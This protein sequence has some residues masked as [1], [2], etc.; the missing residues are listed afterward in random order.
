MK[1]SRFVPFL[2]QLF[3]LAAFIFKA[4]DD[5]LKAGLD[6]FFAGG[7]R[8]VIIAIHPARGNNNGIIPVTINGKNFKAGAAIFLTG[9]EGN[10][11]EARD[12]DVASESVI[13]CSLNLEGQPAGSYAV[14]VV[15]PDRKRTR[16]KGF[17]V[18]DA[19]VLLP[20]ITSVDPA[21]GY[22]TGRVAVTITGKNLRPGVKIFLYAREKGMI[23][24]REI[25]VVAGE[26]M[27]ECTFNLRGLPAGSYLV[28]A[29]NPDGKQCG[30][31]SF[32][33]LDKPV[34]VL[35]IKSMDPSLGF[36]NG[37]IWVRLNIANIKAGARLVLTGPGGE[38]IKA[39]NLII[40]ENGE[41]L[42]IFDLKGKPAGAYEV[43][44]TNPDGRQA[45]YGGKFTV[46]PAPVGL[47]ELNAGIKPIFFNFD[48]ADI[49]P[50]QAPVLE[51]NLK[52]LREHVQLRIMLN[53][54]ADNQGSDRYNTKLSRRRTEAVRNFLT[55]RGIDSARISIHVYGEKYSGKTGGEKQNP[56]FDRRVEIVLYEY[57]L[58]P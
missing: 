23:Y 19:P 53:G 1:K 9:P 50:D 16:L 35:T 55:A 27:V 57:D 22:N 56:A 31:E 45:V 37:K 26:D 43:R 11:V 48:S 10:R 58:N 14:T 7:L 3:V 44:I 18:I 49:R 39:E 5:I 12:V 15:N 21:R 33:V 51:A 6:C 2:I 30:F 4:D 34:P 36:N 41:M 24:G 47:A 40:D 29:V 38:T 20:A 42:C 54:Y 8:P 28:A 17:A 52:I 13:R 46:I 25:T 32:T